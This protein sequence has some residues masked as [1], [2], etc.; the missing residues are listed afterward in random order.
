M[1]L[2][3]GGGYNAIHRKLRTSQH[4]MIGTGICGIIS[5]LFD[6]FLLFIAELLNIIMQNVVMEGKSFP[7]LLQLNLRLS[8]HRS[9]GH[10]GN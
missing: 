2:F 6:N 5:L 4:A 9:I 1:D 7:V 3:F 8:R 10:G